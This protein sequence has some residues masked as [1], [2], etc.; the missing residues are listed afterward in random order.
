ML[1]KNSKTFI[2][3]TAEELGLKEQFVEDVVSFYY[4]TLRKNLVELTSRNIQVE[5]VGSFKAKANELHKLI[6]KYENHLK[7]INPETFNQ[8]TIKKDIE[9]KLERVKR[10]QNLIKDEKKRKIEHIKNKRENGNFRKNL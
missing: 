1:P 6:A 4:K 3:P 7:V 8:M 9:T 5:R 2:A 10:L